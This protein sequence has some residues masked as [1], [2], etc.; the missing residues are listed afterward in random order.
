MSSWCANRG[1]LVL[2]ARLRSRY[3]GCDHR[4]LNSMECQLRGW[5]KWSRDLQVSTPEHPQNSCGSRNFEEVEEKTAYIADILLEMNSAY[6]QR[7]VSLKG[8]FEISFNS[9]G[10]LC[11]PGTKF[12]F[13]LTNISILLYYFLFFFF[14]YFFFFFFKCTN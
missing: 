3:W 1:K 2:T 10:S 4:N 8:G 13:W 12:Y 5:S 11:S 6:G 7:H 9:L 14:I